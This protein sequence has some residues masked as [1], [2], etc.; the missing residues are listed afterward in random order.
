MQ[1]QGA[2]KSCAFMSTLHRCLCE[3]YVR[4]YARKACVPASA[5]ACSHVHARTLHAHDVNS[6]VCFLD[7]RVVGAIVQVF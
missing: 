1:A 3:Q 6:F 7:V 2:R 5:L 4:A